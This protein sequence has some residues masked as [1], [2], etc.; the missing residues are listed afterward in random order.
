MKVALRLDS[1]RSYNKCDRRIVSMS[2]E[3]RNIPS[4]DKILSQSSVK[5]LC[6]VYS[7]TRVTAIVR[8]CLESIRTEVLADQ[9]LP[10]VEHICKRVTEDQGNQKYHF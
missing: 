7:V 5:Q 9:K 8:E 1:H 6:D 3:L 2:R 4:T 10:T